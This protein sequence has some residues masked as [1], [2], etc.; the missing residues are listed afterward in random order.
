M[1]APDET[2]VALASPPGG[3]ATGIVRLSGPD[4]RNCLED[5]FRP[6]PLVRLPLVTVPTVVPGFLW[7]AGFTSPVPCELYLWPGRRSYTR[8]PVAEIH[9]L[10]SPPLLDAVV[11]APARAGHGLRN[12]ANSRSA[13]SSPDASTLL[14]P[15][16]CWE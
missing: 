2:I 16:P 15:R 8:Q 11:A 14:R 10:G 7:L 4:L 12:R 13:H 6:D 5:C 3:G 1:H 9:T